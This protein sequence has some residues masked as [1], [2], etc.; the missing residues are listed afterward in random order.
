MVRPADIGDEVLLAL[1]AGVIRLVGPA[2]WTVV[3]EFLE[4][5]GRVRPLC[6]PERFPFHHAQSPGSVRDRMDRPAFDLFGQLEICVGGFAQIFND[7]L[8]HAMPRDG[9]KTDL[10]AGGCYRMSNLGFRVGISGQKGRNV[11]DGNRFYGHG[12]SSV[13]APSGTVYHRDRRSSSAGQLSH[14]RTV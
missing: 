12:S 9:K 14:V 8:L 1:G 7:I 6:A 3:I 10:S 11:D 4:V 13:I 2:L 5:R